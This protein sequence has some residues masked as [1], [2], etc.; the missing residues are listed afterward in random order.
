M[1]VCVEM[2]GDRRMCGTQEQWQQEV[3]EWETSNGATGADLARVQSPNLDDTLD[4]A[5]ARSGCG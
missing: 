4:R 1:C 3:G 5:A 2:Q